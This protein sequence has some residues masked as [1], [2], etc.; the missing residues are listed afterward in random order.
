[1]ARSIGK[2]FLCFI[3]TVGVL[4]SA[5]VWSVA[6]DK[7]DVDIPPNW[8]GFSADELHYEEV[9]GTYYIYTVNNNEASIINVHTTYRGPEKTV[10]TLPA[11]LGGCPVT[12]LGDIERTP[13]IFLYLN[14]NDEDDEYEY[15]PGLK[16]ITKIIIPEGCEYIAD[17]SLWCGD[18]QDKDPEFNFVFPTS[19]KKIYGYPITA[20]VTD[21]AYGKLFVVPECEYTDFY[22]FYEEARMSLLFDTVVVPARYPE[23]VIEINGGICSDYDNDYLGDVLYL[24]ANLTNETVLETFFYYDWDDEGNDMIPFLKWHMD[25]EIHCAPDCEWLSV[26]AKPEYEDEIQDFIVTDVVPATSIAFD[27]ET[28]YIAQGDY[29]DIAAKTYPSEAMWKTCDYVSSNP[30]VVKINENSG[31]I[32]ALKEGTATITA[33]HCERGFT[34]S[35]NVV[36]LPEGAELP[37]DEPATEEPTTEEPTT[38]EPSTEE[39]TTEEPTTEEPTTEEPTTEE[40]T[41]EEPTTEEPTTEEPT[42]EEPTTEEPTTEEP[43]TEG[44]TTEEPTTEEPTTEE[45]TTEEPTTEEPT[46]EEPTTEEPTTEE[47]TTEEPTT[48]EPTT[49][50]PTTEEPTTEEPTTEESTTEEPTTE[51]PTTEEPPTGSD[52]ESFFARLWNFLV[53]IYRYIVNVFKTIFGVE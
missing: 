34:D 43:T 37:P 4:C 18:S 9:D 30:E 39:P 2:K 24:P 53:R 11:T 50:E 21:G 46:T 28:V 6:A 32:T 23:L 36:V 41:T 40:P 47:P 38:E 10:L 31:R 33:T 25:F 26:F 42:T 35:Y 16:Y 17:M 52:G 3:L 51:E 7:P 1:M 49:E 15:D 48:E 22:W 29:R 12:T 13:E 45:P 44:P 14:Y 5:L 20:M 19:L 8:Y 27:N